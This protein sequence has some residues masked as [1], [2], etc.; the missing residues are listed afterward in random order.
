MLHEILLSLAGH[1]SP[2]LPARG[3]TDL[4]PASFPLLSPPERALLSSLARL[5]QLHRDL[6]QHTSVICASHDSIVCRAVSTSIVNT[7]LA[8]FQAKIIDVEGRILQ[9]DADTVVPEG[10]VPLSGLVGSFDEWTRRMEWFWEIASFMTATGSGGGHRAENIQQLASSC[11]GAEI[12][13]KLRQEAHTGYLDIEQA[14]LE[15]ISV[16]ETAWL[17]QLSTWVLYGR[18]PLAGALDFFIQTEDDENST[19]PGGP[20]PGFSVLRKLLPSFVSTPTASSILFIGRALNHLRVRGSSLVSPSGS[21]SSSPELALLPAHLEHLSQLNSPITLVNF[22]KTIAAIRVSVARNTLQQ[23]LPLPRILEILEV[24]RDFF[25]LAR[26][27]FA[28]A[29]ISEADERARSRWRRPGQTSRSDSS[30]ELGSVVVK[31]GE[32]NA[33]LTR[34]WASLSS[35]SQ[36]DDM[37]DEVLELAR[38]LISLTLVRSSPS[39]GS[40]P[41]RT[42]NSTE[43]QSTLATVT[44][45]DLL[46]STPA[47]LSLNI[48]S[49]LDLFLSPNDLE[50]YSAINSYLL[51]IRRA[52]RRLTELWTLSSLR[53]RY[54]APLGPPLSNT[55]TGKEKNQ[56]ARERENL[57][58]DSLRSTWATCSAAVFLLVELG[59]Y[60]QGEVIAGSWDEF[61]QWLQPQKV[62]SAATLPVEVR[63]GASK[64]ETGGDDG[65]ATD[66]SGISSP[67]TANAEQETPHDPE[68][69]AR[70]HGAYLQHLLS[71]LLLTDI[72]FTRHIRQLLLKLDQLVATGARLSL[73]QQ[74]LDTEYDRGGFPDIHEEETET[75]ADLID[76]GRRVREGVGHVVTRLRELDNVGESSG[77]RGVGRLVMRLDFGNLVELAGVRHDEEEDSFESHA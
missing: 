37:V 69:I 40:T 71:H 55:P 76:V 35:H 46:L 31:E 65:A 45:N 26:G 70:H 30:R 14:A 63:T 56:A 61:R 60:F 22:S 19:L 16:A 12:I 52:H 15:L 24:L 59:E 66:K 17:R 39:L 43:D 13:D 32:A 42:R 62:A 64:D 47:V 10:I 51:C 67:S 53:R 34:T 33:V 29:L 2:L 72:P 11:S 3:K 25:L 44:F 57:R 48:A 54:P 18:L 28:I 49:P 36:D 58:S 41:N 8:R 6:L 4:S 73:V 27:E 20:N 38:D 1:E 5:S 74:S 7:H 75:M 68:T 50:T 77:G 9:K 21:T 23:L